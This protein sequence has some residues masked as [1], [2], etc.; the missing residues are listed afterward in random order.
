MK[1]NKPLA[2]LGKNPLLNLAMV[3]QTIHDG[4]ADSPTETNAV[5][6][7][8]GNFNE[9]YEARDDVLRWSES[10][11]GYIYDLEPVVAAQAGALAYLLHAGVLQEAK[12]IV[13]TVKGT[14]DEDIEE[15][16]GFEVVINPVQFA[17]YYSRIINLAKPYLG[18][19][20]TPVAKP[21]PT[22]PINNADNLKQNHRAYLHLINRTLKL[23][24]NGNEAS[25]TV[26]KFKTKSANNYIACRA[27]CA[28]KN[29][30]LNK[31]DLGIANAK[32]VIK[33]LPK[34]MGISG[35]LQ[36]FFIEIDSGGQRILMRDIVK[37]SNYERENLTNYVQPHFQ[38]GGDS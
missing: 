2:E 28:K 4:L 14:F 21:A 3:A 17:D 10:E 11:A 1:A 24:F 6:I 25:Y 19:D 26:C 35:P 36:Q 7:E 38:A 12:Q 13:R 16:V 27:L 37:M 22:M 8:A 18:A 30:W 29:K 31:A 34:T 5:S 15:T 23:Y 9:Y 20:S 33:D 32:S